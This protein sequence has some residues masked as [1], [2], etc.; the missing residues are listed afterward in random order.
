M[1]PQKYGDI[2]L[3]MTKSLVSVPCET[4]LEKEVC[5]WEATYQHIHLEIIGVGPWVGMGA[6]HQL[7]WD[8]DVVPCWNLDLERSSDDR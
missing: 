3:A 4:V 8:F 1:C 7:C 2:A 5:K 6:F